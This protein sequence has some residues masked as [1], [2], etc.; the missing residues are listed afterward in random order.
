MNSGGDGEIVRTWALEVGAEELH[1]ALIHEQRCV[2][3][4]GVN[5][6]DADRV[7]T[8]FDGE[9]AHQTDHAVL[10]GDVVARVRICLQPAD[11]TGED[12][13]TALRPGRSG[14]GPR[15]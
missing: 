12:D 13:R 4:R 15:L 2:H 11:R 5:G 8:K 6:I 9:G 7:L 3:V 10:G 14:A 1:G